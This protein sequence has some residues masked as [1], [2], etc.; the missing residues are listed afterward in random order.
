MKRMA[1][2]L[3]AVLVSCATS[4]VAPGT[5]DETIHKNESR[6]AY[7][8]CMRQPAVFPAELKQICYRQAVLREMDWVWRNCVNYPKLYDFKDCGLRPT[9]T[10]VIEAGH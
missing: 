6:R 2:L 3:L 5:L 9:M 10:D 7:Q 8:Q 1:T 4:G